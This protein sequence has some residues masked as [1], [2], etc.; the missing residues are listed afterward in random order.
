MIKATHGSKS[1]LA[2][3]FGGMSLSRHRSEAAV[4]NVIKWQQ[5]LEA[6]SSHLN[7]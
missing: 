7:H 4:I 1:L 6:E 3:D 5:E 2:Y